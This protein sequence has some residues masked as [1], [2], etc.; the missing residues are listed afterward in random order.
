MGFVC[1][2]PFGIVVGVVAIATA[3]I[4][5]Y[6][7]LGG[8]LW[9]RQNYERRRQREDEEERQLRRKQKANPNPRSVFSVLYGGTVSE[10]KPLVFHRRVATPDGRRFIGWFDNVMFDMDMVSEFIYKYGTTA[11]RQ[12]KDEGGNIVVVGDVGDFDSFMRAEAE[13][14]KWILPPEFGAYG[15][16]IGETGDAVVIKRMDEL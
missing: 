7:K 5:L 3:G 1:A 14:K 9:L 8:W 15:N 16:D 10:R 4:L 6:K 2:Y 13:I 12:Y 11:L